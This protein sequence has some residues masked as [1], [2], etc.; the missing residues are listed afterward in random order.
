MS[1]TN[2]FTLALCILTALVMS[3]QVIPMEADTGDAGHADGPDAPEGVQDAAGPGIRGVEDGVEAQGG[4]WLDPFDDS[5]GDEAASGMHYYDGVRFI[6]SGADGRV[7]LYETNNDGFVLNGHMDSLRI[8]PIN[9]DYWNT[10][11]VQHKVDQVD[12]HTFKVSILDWKYNPISPEFTDVDMTT[13]KF[14]D[15]SSIDTQTY[16]NISIRGKLHTENQ[17]TS[18][19]ILEWKLNWS[20]NQGPSAKAIQS[21]D[22]SVKR[23]DHI[24]LQVFGKDKEDEDSE[25]TAVMEAK[26]HLGGSWSSVGFSNAS[27]Y[28]DKWNG[29]SGWTLTFT[30][31]LTNKIGMYDFRAALVD[32]RAKQGDWFVVENLLEVMNNPPSRPHIVIDPYL[33]GTTDDLF[34]NITVPSKDLED[35]DG[36]ITYDYVWKRDGVIQ[37][38]EGPTVSSGLTTKGQFWEC[39]VTPWDTD[40]PGDTLIDMATIENTNALIVEA[41]V[42]FE[43]YED[44]VDYSIDLQTI[45][46]DPDGDEL[47]YSIL[48]TKRV[49]FTILGNGRTV[50]IKPEADWHGVEKVYLAATDNATGAGGSQVPLNI[51]V[52]EINDPPDITPIEGAAVDE[53]YYFNYTVLATDRDSSKVL[54]YY[55]DETTAPEDFAID[56]NTGFMSYLAQNDH[57]GE[58]NITIRVEDDE[59]EPRNMSFWLSVINV[60]DPP[61]N[62]GILGVSDEQNFFV[63]DV[64][65]FEANPADDPDSMHGQ[66][67]NYTWY[68]DDVVVGT[69]DTYNYKFEREGTVKITLMVDDGEYY[70]NETFNITVLSHDSAGG[71]HTSTEDALDQATIIGIVVAAILGVMVIIIVALYLRHR[72]RTAQDE[73]RKEY[74]QMQMDESRKSTLASAMYGDG[75]APSPGGPAGPEGPG[76]APGAAPGMPAGG[77]GAVKCF[78][79]GTQVPIPS[80]ERPVVVTCPQCG[81]QGKISK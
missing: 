69:T 44:G 47:Y 19:E 49:D 78:Q 16:G 37:D 56:R 51:T 7:E 66:T 32:S 22:D 70:V 9:N 6:G 39:L 45:F 63:K 53:G 38:V 14:L 48:N 24:N 72:H 50:E 68:V 76:G 1:K 54:Y 74:E 20:I 13:N 30:P 15:I 4:Y 75:M 12:G 40:G 31:L 10:F 29:Y 65:T 62:K 28:A 11:R 41:P 34:L 21:V 61:E 55:V 67:L 18:P 33:P 2:L 27:A 77:F 17:W 71:K 73:G 58:W 3:S 8:D 43:M 79:C 81:T 35:D 80:P 52:W 23:G 36:E 5:N 42:D 25:L 59:F 64:V 26:P 46:T 60:N 57:V